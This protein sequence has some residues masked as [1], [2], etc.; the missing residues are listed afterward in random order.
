MMRKMVAC[1]LA[2]LLP[3]NALAMEDG[4]YRDQA[5]GYGGDVIVTVVI[6]DGRIREVS[7]ENTGGEKSEYY[8]KAEQALTQ[9]IVERQG[10]ENV[11]TVAG[12]TGTSRSILEAMQG[13][14][15]QAAYSGSFDTFTQ[16]AAQEAA[17][18]SD[19]VSRTALL[20]LP[21]AG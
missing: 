12:A 4:I 11:D 16:P 13:I 7:T 20:R 17:S 10:I 14:L 2:L 1:L 3:A 5:A 9:A 18:S 8:L 21:A 19:S 15:Q 6:R